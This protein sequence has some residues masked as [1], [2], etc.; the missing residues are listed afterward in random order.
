MNEDR[1]DFIATLE[2]VIRQRLES[3]DA[4]SYTA[5]LAAEG[6]S[7][8]AQKVGEEA[9]ELAIAAVGANREAT[10]EEAADLL[11]HMLVLLAAQDLSLADVV[12]ILETRHS[13]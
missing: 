9:V 10:L 13:G 8:L 4:N 12:A 5:R 2:S 7:R 3:G 6:A 1:L 11:Y